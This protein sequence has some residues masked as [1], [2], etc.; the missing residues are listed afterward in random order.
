MKLKYLIPLL[1]T[2]LLTGCGQNINNKGSERIEFTRI[3]DESTDKSDTLRVIE[4]NTRVGHEEYASISIKGRPGE[5]YS[6]TSNYKW[7]GDS[8]TA[9]EKRRAGNDGVATWIWRVRSNTTPG[10]YPII[11][12]GGGQRLE[13]SYTVLS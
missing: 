7:G 10:T 6:I 3:Q 1:I 4:S 9:F 12:T 5:T 2:A 8:V 13:T 11:I